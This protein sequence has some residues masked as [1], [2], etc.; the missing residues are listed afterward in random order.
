MKIKFENFSVSG[1]SRKYRGFDLDI[2]GHSIGDKSITLD[3]PLYLV[4]D[5]CQHLKTNHP[6]IKITQLNEDEVP[7]PIAAEV[8]EEEVPE[9]DGREEEACSDEVP[10]RAEWANPIENVDAGTEIAAPPVTEMDVPQKA[11]RPARTSRKH[12]GKRK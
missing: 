4:E 2:P 3:V 7:L 12:G 10:P 6:A 9:E 1:V 11:N 8:S 5:I